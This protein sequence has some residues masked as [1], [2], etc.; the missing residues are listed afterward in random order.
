MQCITGERKRQWCELVHVLAV[1]GVVILAIRGE[2]LEQ[3]EGWMVY[4]PHWV[5]LGEERRREKHLR[6]GIAWSVGWVWMRRSWRSALVRSE[7]LLLLVVWSGHTEREWVCLLPWASW[8]W[9]GIGAACAEWRGC[10]VYRSVDDRNVSSIVRQLWTEFRE[11]ILAPWAVDSV[12][13]RRT[14][15]P[16]LPTAPTTTTAR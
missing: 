14:R 9:R 13:S 4:R 16:T 1:V 15:L 10:A 5:R 12:D 3:L 7:A 6:G 11:H 2:G 8:L